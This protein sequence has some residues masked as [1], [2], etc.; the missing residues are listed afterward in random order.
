MRLGGF[1]TR[2]VRRVRSEAGFGLIELL[3]ALVVMN[4]AVMALVAAL[5][6]SHVS[7]VRASRTSTAAAVANAELEQYRALTWAGVPSAT[8]TPVSKTG[9]DGRTYTLATTGSYE[10]PNAPGTAVTATTTCAS[11][12]RP[13][14]RVTVVVSDSSGSLVTQTTTFDQITG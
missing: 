8:L 10:C 11:G 4:I 5:T 13:V 12:G 1:A 7:L 9:A 3:V 2:V 6:S 14:K